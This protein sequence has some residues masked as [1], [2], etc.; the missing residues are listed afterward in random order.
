MFKKATLLFLL[1]SFT[2]YGQ[3]K[4]E[5]VNSFTKELDQK[6]PGLLKDF[7][8]PGTAIAI[9][10]NGELVLQKAYGYA[11]IAQ[12][13][14]VTTQTGFNIGSISKTIAAWGIMKLV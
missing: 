1:M 5:D 14:K 8:V 2:F 11:D 4:S 13:K 3:T 12:G 7:M 10:E 6:I 9:I